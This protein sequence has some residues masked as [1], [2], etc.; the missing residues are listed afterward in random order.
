MIQ[1]PNFKLLWLHVQANVEHFMT[2]KRGYFNLFTFPGKRNINIVLA[3]YGLLINLF[4]PKT[5]DN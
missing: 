1:G 2:Y 4:R 3:R 5:L